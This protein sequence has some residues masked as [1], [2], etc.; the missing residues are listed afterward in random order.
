MQASYISLLNATEA[1]YEDLE[2]QFYQSI[3]S[4]DDVP[5]YIGI[6]GGPLF[7]TPLANPLCNPVMLCVQSPFP[8]SLVVLVAF[9][10]SPHQ[11]THMQACS[12][13]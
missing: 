13:A 11:P 6:S 10:E 4:C 8:T 7:L 5:Y 1:E 9:A 12:T 3:Y 2:A